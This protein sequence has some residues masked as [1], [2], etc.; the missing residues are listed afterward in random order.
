MWL[1]IVLGGNPKYFYPT[2]PE[3]E[4]IL[5]IAPTENI[6]VSNISKMVTDT[7][8]DSKEVRYETT[9]GFRLG[10]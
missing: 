3:V 7:M 8:L 6:L 10:L 5:T 1:P 2:K 9:N 4:L